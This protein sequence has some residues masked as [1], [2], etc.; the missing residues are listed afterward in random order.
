MRI[1]CGVTIGVPPA[2]KRIYC[3]LLRIR[4]A[5]VGSARITPALQSSRR[6]PPGLRPEAGEALAGLIRRTHCPAPQR[7]LDQIEPQLK[8]EPHAEGSTRASTADLGRIGN[9]SNEEAQG[10]AKGREIRRAFEEMFPPDKRD[11][12]TSGS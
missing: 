9:R 8:R 12:S 11:P 5:T 2:N 6:V 7:S 1:P 4:S 10:S 3:Q